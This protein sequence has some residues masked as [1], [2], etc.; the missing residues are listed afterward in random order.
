MIPAYHPLLNAILPP[1]CGQGAVDPD[2][3]GTA[4]VSPAFNQT[5]AGSFRGWRSRGYLP[6]FD[7]P[8]LVQ[9][10]VFRLADSLPAGIGEKI[11]TFQ[12]EDRAFAIDTSLDAGH[13]RRDL[14]VTD[15]AEMVEKALLAFDHERYELIAWCVMP[16][17]VHT[18][19]TLKSGYALDRVIHSWKSYTA[20]KANQT[21][22]RSGSFWAPEYFDRFMRDEEHLAAT[23]TYIEG[24]PVKAGLC[25]SVSD[26]RFSSAWLGWS[27]RDARGPASR[28]EAGG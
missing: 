3:S 13:G 1:G 21:L 22:G 27:G 20:K 18:L 19:L 7:V 10:I 25:E 23:A 8:N 2:P 17:H 24:N 28:L 6:R 16:N 4:G 14:A 12:H 9:H 5:T 26:W 11:A 15:V